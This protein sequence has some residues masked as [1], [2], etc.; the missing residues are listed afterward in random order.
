MRF[1][2]VFRFI[3]NVLV[4]VFGKL[5]GVILTMF[6]Y[7]HRVFLRS[8][9]YNFM[10]ANNLKMN[11]IIITE[12]KEDRYIFPNGYLM[13]RK[14]NKLLGYALLY[15]WFFLD[16]DANLTCCSLAYTKKEDVEG[17]NIE[18]SFFELGDKQALN[19]VSIWTNWNNFKEFF[20]W[21]VRRNGFYNYNYLVEDG[22]LDSCGTL[23]YPPNERIHESNKSLKNF[24]EHRFYQDSNGK[25]FFI[26]TL[27][28]MYKG[29]A[30]GYEF[31]F[32]RLPGNRVNAVMRVYWKKSFEGNK[33]D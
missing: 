5:K 19:I 26:A 4:S 1:L 31:G 16:D 32:R 27:C 13:K 8:Y 17:L 6:I 21:M 7:P 12:E 30:Y 20:Y 3:G 14:T 22:Y 18:G 10:I 2:S 33:G 24:N 29:K 23:P 11:R 25:W 9:V 28:R 15:P